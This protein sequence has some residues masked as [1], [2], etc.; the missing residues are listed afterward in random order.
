M[1]LKWFSI[2]KELQFYLTINIASKKPTHIFASP[3]TKTLKL[4]VTVWYSLINY[5]TFASFCV[6]FVYVSLLY[7]FCHFLAMCIVSVGS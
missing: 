2:V 4:I 6:F 1:L 5:V 7:L 3:L